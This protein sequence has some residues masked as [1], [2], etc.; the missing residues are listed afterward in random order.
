MTP[1]V[2]R[3]TSARRRGWARRFLTPRSLAARGLCAITKDPEGK[4][5]ENHIQRPHGRGRGSHG[6]SRRGA[7]AH[8]GTDHS[9][10]ILH[11]DG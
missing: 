1:A 11:L 8:W 7:C 5:H 10:D 2:G 6:D 3:G 9:V 4:A